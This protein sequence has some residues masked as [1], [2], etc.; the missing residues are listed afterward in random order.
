MTVEQLVERMT[1][2]RQLLED[3]Q[4]GLATWNALFRNA[5]AD[6]RK[7]VEGWYEDGLT[8]QTFDVFV[9]EPPSA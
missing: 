6:L 2:V 8:V 1:R 7:V 9:K 3:P 5:M 4:P